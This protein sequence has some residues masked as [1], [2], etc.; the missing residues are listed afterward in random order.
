M[1]SFN[2]YAYGAVGDWLYRTVAG[3]APTAPGYRTIRVRPRPGGGLSHA[4][5]ELATVHGRAAVAWRDEAGTFVLDVTVPPN[6]TAEVWVPD[7]DP[8]DV[9]EGGTRAS[10]A[11]GVRASHRAEDGSAVFTVG[12]GTYRFRRD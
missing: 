11:D 4:E 2:H 9:T 10:D 3:L 12:S 5:A 8:A 1:T 6:T 7:A